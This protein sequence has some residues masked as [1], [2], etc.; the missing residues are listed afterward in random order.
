MSILPKAPKVQGNYG[1]SPLLNHT[2][3]FMTRLSLLMIVLIGSC[4]SPAAEDK[5]TA[6]QVEMQFDYLISVNIWNG[7]F[8][9]GS[10][11]ILDNSLI[12]SYDSIQNSSLQK[13]LTLY[14]ISF[15]SKPQINENAFTHKDTIEILFSKSFSDT[16][17]VL[18]KKFFRSLEFN[19]YDTIGQLMPTISD[20]SHAF[21]DLQYRGRRLSATI[22]SINNPTIATKDLDTLLSFVNKFR[23][24]D[25]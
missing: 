13:P 1:K 24:P 8:G 10:K 9:H 19:N 2:V 6:Y 20:D 11:F 12:N 16:L 25:K 18:T 5:A 3:N 23:P 22:S 21:I 4:N 15:L 14:Y 7:F 17:F